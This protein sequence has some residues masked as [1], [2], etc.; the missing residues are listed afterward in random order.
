M[1]F[2]GSL[3][4][5]IHVVERASQKRAK[6]RA[7]ASRLEQVSEARHDAMRLV[8][9]HAPTMQ[10]PSNGAALAPLCSLLSLLARLAFQVLVRLLPLKQVIEVLGAALAKKV[11]CKAGIWNPEEE[12]GCVSLSP[13]PCWSL[14]CFF[15]L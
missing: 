6:R 10:L 11:R 5:V 12:V 13:C 3:H 7:E 4:S 8:P 1:D 14:L 15:G 9:L 2:F